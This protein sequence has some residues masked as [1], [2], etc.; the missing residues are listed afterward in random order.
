MARRV[1]VQSACDIC[2]KT[3]DEKFTVNICIIIGPDQNEVD[4][5]ESCGQDF[6]VFLRAARSIPKSEQYIPPTKTRKSHRATAPYLPKAATDVVEE[7]PRTVPCDVKGCKYMGVDNRA[8]GVHKSRVHG[9]KG[10]TKK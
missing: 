8:I 2:G 4:V 5:C 7:R 1:V 10:A 6:G 9:I 3:G